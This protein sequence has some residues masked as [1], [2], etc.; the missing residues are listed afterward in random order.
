MTKFNSSGARARAGASFIEAANEF[1]LNH[2]GNLGQ[3][4]TPKSELFLAMVSDFGGENTFYESAAVRTQRIAKLVEVVAVEDPEWIKNFALWLRN[5]ANMRT[6]SLILVLESAKALIKAG[7][8]GA[9]QIIVNA[10]SRADEPGEALAWWYANMGRKLPAAVKRGIADGAVKTY[11]EFTLGKYD[12]ESHGF[13]F[14]DVIN[15]THPN[16]TDARQ[17]DVF[18][19]ALDRRRDNNAEIPASLTM[20]QKRKAILSSSPEEK[21]ALLLSANASAELKAAG[22]TWENVGSSFG[23]GGLDATAWAALIPTMGYM[24]LIR[25]LRNFEEAGVSANVL[26]QVAARIANQEEVAKSKQLPFRF[27]SAHRAVSGHVTNSWGHVTKNAPGSGRFEFPLEQALNHS[28]MNIPSLDGDTLILTDRSGSM[29]YDVSKNSQMNFADTG[30]LFAAALA[31]RANKA[32]L[33][34]FGSSS[35]EVSFNKNSSILKIV[36]NLSSLGGTSTAAAVRK[37]WN[38][39]YS[40]VIIVTD[41]QSYG[42]DPANQVP[43]NVPVYTFN[44]AGYRYGH[45]ATK[46]NR[47]AFGG[48]TDQSFALIPLL[49]AGIDAKWPWEK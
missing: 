2:K 11:N 37:H 49:E 8:P 17:S 22:L 15:L 43:D 40:R 27:L 13:R 19:Y 38:K 20:L 7:I 24:A 25:N 29:F 12:T 10:I 35:Q 3:A 30:G 46:P 41:E 14:A 48:L 33:V 4:R 18:K 9:R 28:L 45:P 6:I 36:N 32:T 1:G 42:G 31:V 44:L 16:P 39:K 23:K 34:E 47:I 5:E 26:D 21:R